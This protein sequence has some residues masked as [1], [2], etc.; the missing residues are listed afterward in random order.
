MY[1]I[2]KLHNEVKTLRS[3][4]VS[5]ENAI[6]Y[7]CFKWERCVL[8]LLLSENAVF[9][10]CL[11]ENTVFYDCFE[12]RTLRSKIFLKWERCVLY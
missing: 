12:V 9:Y 4:I 1:I 11:S 6:F 2:L 5:T 10:D 3:K 8:W 7:G